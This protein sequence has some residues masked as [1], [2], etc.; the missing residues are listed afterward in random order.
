VHAYSL[1]LYIHTIVNIFCSGFDVLLDEVEDL[2]LD[3]PDAEEV[4]TCLIHAMIYIFTV[5]LLH[6]YLGTSLLVQ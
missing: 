2:K 1:A 5:Y 3:T 6:R 4:Y